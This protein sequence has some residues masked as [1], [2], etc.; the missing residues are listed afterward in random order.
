MRH[1]RGIPGEPL[2]TGDSL[3]LFW[4]IDLDKT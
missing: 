1:I 2:F 3:Y 4:W